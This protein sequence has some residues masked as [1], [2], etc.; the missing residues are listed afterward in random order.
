MHYISRLQSQKMA[1][2][3]S[4]TPPFGKNGSQ[5]LSGV[6]PRV[7]CQRQHLSVI[8][9]AGHLKKT[10]TV[11]SCRGKCNKCNIYLCMDMYIRITS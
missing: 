5:R 2:K 7:C 4:F 8:T 6:P 9:S 11:L 10:A 1:S 3:E